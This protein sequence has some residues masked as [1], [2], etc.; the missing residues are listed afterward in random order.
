MKQ[1]ERIVNA[2]RVDDLIAVFGSFDENIKRSAERELKTFSSFASLTPEAFGAELN[3]PLDSLPLYHSEQADFVKEYEARLNE[4]GQY[5]Y[6]I[7]S[8]SAI[9]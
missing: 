9:R 7:F 2:D 6:G 1:V 5:G 8:S 4:L 3:E